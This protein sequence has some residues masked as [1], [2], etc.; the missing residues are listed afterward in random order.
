M[1]PESRKS[2]YTPVPRIEFEINALNYDNFEL[3]YFC[4]ECVQ[5]RQV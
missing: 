5:N 3:S 2:N 4:S 1:N